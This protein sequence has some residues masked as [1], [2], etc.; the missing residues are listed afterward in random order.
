MGG[1]PSAKNLPHVQKRKDH[2]TCHND[3]NCESKHCLPDCNSSKTP[4]W[5]CVESRSFYRRHGIDIPTCARSEISNMSNNSNE[6]KKASSRISNDS[7]TINQIRSTSS[8]N[9]GEPCAVDENCFSGNCV[10]VC[11]DKSPTSQSHCIESKMSF[12]RHNLSIPKCVSRKTV[13][14]LLS[15]FGDSNEELSSENE[16]KDVDSKEAPVKTNL[17]G[18]L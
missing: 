1:V 6:K 8:K 4:V 14:D 10:P 12:S 9:I 15:L 3:I 5:K 13:D 11:D 18:W 2:E 16:V 7:N 17:R